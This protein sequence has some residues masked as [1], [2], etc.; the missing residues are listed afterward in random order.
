M[1]VADVINTFS[2]SCAEWAFT[3][4]S[5]VVRDSSTELHHSRWYPWRCCFGLP[6]CAALVQTGTASSEVT[7]G[8]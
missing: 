2:A 6:L 8:C 3:L 7:A 4:F 1:C 5:A